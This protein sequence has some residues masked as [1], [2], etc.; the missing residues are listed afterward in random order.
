MGR[1]LESMKKLNI[2]SRYLEV[3]KKRVLKSGC[4]VLFSYYAL[5]IGR[6]VNVKYK[7]NSNAGFQGAT[8]NVL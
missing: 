3:K 4:Y 1:S 6:C 8:L 7:L 5:V 2:T